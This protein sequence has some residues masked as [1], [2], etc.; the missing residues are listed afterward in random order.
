MKK[1][2]KFLMYLNIEKALKIAF[3]SDEIETSN[4]LLEALESILPFK[5][6]SEHEQF[7]D[8]TQSFKD[9]AEFHDFVF[10]VGKRLNEEE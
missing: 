3:S 9:Y 10:N 7:L 6:E 4:K 2:N 8:I 5:D 1:T